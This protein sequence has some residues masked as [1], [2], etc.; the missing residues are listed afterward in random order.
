MAGEEVECNPT[1]VHFKWDAVDWL[2]PYFRS[3]LIEV[4]THEILIVLLGKYEF[5]LEVFLPSCCALSGLHCIRQSKR[6][7]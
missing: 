6:T 3:K 4:Q 5:I 7:R 1:S 2:Y